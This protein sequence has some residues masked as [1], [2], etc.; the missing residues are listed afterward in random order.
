MK[1]TTEERLIRLEKSY[2]KMKLL[3]VLSA[4]IAVSVAANTVEAKNI[5]FTLKYSAVARIT[6]SGKMDV[7][8]TDNDNIPCKIEG[9]NE[10]KAT[11]NGKYQLIRL[12]DEPDAIYYLQPATH[13]IVIW[14]YFKKSHSVTYCKLRAFPSTGL[15]D[16]YLMIA[17][18]E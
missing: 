1:L 12:H 17:K 5:Q 18:C 10:E 11:F 4:V 9:I 8:T 16:S 6:E 14:V 15:P 3:F 7:H 13:G 2:R